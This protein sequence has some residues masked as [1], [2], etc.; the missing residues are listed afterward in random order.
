MTN[1]PVE[2]VQIPINPGDLLAG[3]YRIE[4]M[5]GRGGMSVL[6]LAK[7]VAL[8]QQVAVKCLLPS[9]AAKA[10][11]V[12]RFLREARAVARLRSR[13]VAGVL[14]VGTAPGGTPYMV[15]EYLEGA[16]L[17]T[18]CEAKG[19]LPVTEAVD[20]I[21][22]AL[23]AVGEAHVNG[24]VHRD[25]KPS[26]LFVAEEAEGLVL[27]VLDFGIS[28]DSGDLLGP[29]A[30]L[31]Q[32]QTIIGSPLYMSPEQ[33][34]SSRSV[35]VRSD[36]W[37][38]GV[39]LYELL[40]GRTPFAGETMGE[41]FACI[42]EV[43][44]PPLPFLRP[45]VPA[46]LAEAVHRCLRR[47]LDRRFQDA[48]ELARALAPYA[49]PRLKPLAESITAMVH[50]VRLPRASLTASLREAR[51]TRSMQGAVMMGQT[52][53][54]TTGKRKAQRWLALG[55][56]AVGLTSGIGLT[57]WALGGR[58]REGSAPNGATSLINV[59]SASSG[60]SA[61]ADVARGQTPALA[62]LPPA[63]ATAPPGATLPTG[64]V[65]AAPAAFP[66]GALPPE[67]PSRAAVEPP[68]VEVVLSPLPPSGRRAGHGRRGAK[69]PAGHASAVPPEPKAAP[70]PPTAAEPP[71][72][73]AVP[74]SV[75]DERE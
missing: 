31:T 75:L 70:D 13:H 40:A 34:R 72:A 8:D 15:I 60:L 32:S 54:E 49:S 74:P 44:F 65:P 58:H 43:D 51:T 19:R 68:S 10:E 17:S 24:V 7:H 27:K 36:L 69:P 71:A 20:Y 16:D 61:P 26:N 57:A 62:T 59:P 2:P 33:I 5:I 6:F 30:K 66:A 22:Q 1:L 50:N 11:S 55:F 64:T 3:K 39:I 63:A 56:G 46:P 37:S 53:L 9:M 42:L 25:L 48:G 38:L 14:D 12:G 67:A 47:P 4:R 29:D 23:D 73:D 41:L 45:D 28:K 52:P 18:V 21:M 35:D